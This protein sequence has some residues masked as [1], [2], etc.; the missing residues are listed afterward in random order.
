VCCVGSGHCGKLTT[1][2]EKFDRVWCVIVCDLGT[3]KMRRPR[4]IM[5][6]TLSKKSREYV[7]LN[8][9]RTVY[10]EVIDLIFSTYSIGNTSK[11]VLA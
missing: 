7:A 2:S 5:V 3:S 11:A 8:W 10:E 9:E 6:F 1:R 4:P